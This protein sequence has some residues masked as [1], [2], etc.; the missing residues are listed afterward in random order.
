LERTDGLVGD[1][2]AAAPQ[3]A[4]ASL[5]RIAAESRLESAESRKQER[6]R[7][8]ETRNERERN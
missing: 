6:E 1:L 8:I 7:L 4:M 3:V 2:R 5:K